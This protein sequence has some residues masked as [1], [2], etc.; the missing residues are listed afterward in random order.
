MINVIFSTKFRKQYRKSEQVIQDS[1]NKRLEIFIKNQTDVRL[2]NHSLVGNFRGCRS[3]N[4]NGD[5]R[6]IFSIVDEGTIVF[7]LMGTHSQ[8]YR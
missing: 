5:W 7:E 8:L 3:I 1:F 4:I 2:N 6:A